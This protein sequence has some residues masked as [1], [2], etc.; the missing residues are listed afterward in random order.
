METLHQT[1]QSN[2]A[3][4]GDLQVALM[5]AHSLRG[6]SSLGEPQATSPSWEI[7]GNPWGTLIY[8]PLVNIQK[9]NGKITML[10]MG[11]SPFFMGKSPFFMGKAM[12]NPL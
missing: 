1:W 2:M 5:S 6:S 8:Y 7:H 11:K 4:Y 9:T 12:E 10:L 3:S